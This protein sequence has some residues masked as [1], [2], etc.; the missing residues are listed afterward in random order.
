MDLTSGATALEDLYPYFA[1]QPVSTRSSILLEQPFTILIH[2]GRKIV[3][4]RKI[5]GR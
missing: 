4:Q 1:D 5:S 3:E 2:E